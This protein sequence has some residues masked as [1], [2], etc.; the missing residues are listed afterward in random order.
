MQLCY[1]MRNEKI[2][3]NSSHPLHQSQI[4][5]IKMDSTKTNLLEKQP[6]AENNTFKLYILSLV[7]VLSLVLPGIIFITTVINL[8]ESSPSTAIHVM[9]LAPTPSHSIQTT[10]CSFAPYKRLCHNTLSS[11]TDNSTLPLDDVFIFRSFQLGVNQITRLANVSKLND[12]P[13]LQEC[14]VLLNKEMSELNNSVASSQN[15]DS[16]RQE[17]NEYLDR[18]KRIETYQ[19]A[20]LIKLQ[21][22]T[23]SLKI[24]KIRSNVQKMR[25]Y[26]SNNRAILLNIDAIVDE[27][28]S[29]TSSS[30]QVDNDSIRTT[31]SFADFFYGMGNDYMIIFILQY[32]YLLCVL[33]SMLKL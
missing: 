6:S 15:H 30:V 14:R 24:D 3:V 29:S 2:F 8:R 31:H 25:R 27:I 21:E 22:S 20:C 18:F 5:F 32:V 19:Q 13:E 33:I 12:I 28:Y 17:I 23:G 16:F 9:N 10:I 11:S 1:Q 4:N 7:I 26:M